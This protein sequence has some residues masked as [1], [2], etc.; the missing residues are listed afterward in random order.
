M[1]SQSEVL[2]AVVQ[3]FPFPNQISQID[4]SSDSKG[5]YFTWRHDRF[6][7]EVGSGSV[8]QVI[9]SCLHG[10]NTAILAESLV[11]SALLKIYMERNDT[12]SNK[13]SVAQG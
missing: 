7:V 2:E 6:K 9:G 3:C 10:N 8:Y 13:Q 12:A 1:Y 11:K 4:I 5:V